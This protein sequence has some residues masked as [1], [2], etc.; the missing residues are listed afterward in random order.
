MPAFLTSLRHPPSRSVALR[1]TLASVIA[2][3]VAAMIG[4]ALP[5]WAAMAVW[6]IGQPPRGLLFERSLAQL[7]GTVAGASAGAVLVI[8][9]AGSA[10]ATLLG[11]AVWIGACCGLANRMRHQRAYGAVVCGLTSVV[12]VALTLHTPALTPADPIAF[13]VA[14]VLDNM[15]G[16][17]AALSVALAFGPPASRSTVAA[18]ANSVM[19]RTL[20]L[21]AEALTEPVENTVVKEREFLLALASLEATA[22]DAAAGSMVGRRE[23]RDIKGLFACLLDLIVVARAIRSQETF[24][25]LKDHADL[26]DLKGAIGVAASGLATSQKLEVAAVLQATQRLQAADRTLAPVLG[27]MRDLLER[28]ARG[29][30][31]LWRE[32]TGPDEWTYHPHPDTTGLKRAMARGTLVILIAS[33]VWLTF[34][35][36]PLRYFLLGAGIFTV[37]FSA[38]D[39][40]APVVRQVFLGG[41]A[42]APAATLWRLA[43]VSEVPNGWL[44]LALAIPLIFAAS[45]L[46]AQ[47]STMF[48][49]LAFNM[50]FAVLARPV[51]T[52]PSTALTMITNETLLLAGIAMTY[53]CFR[54]VLPMTTDRRRDHLKSDVQR[55]VRAIAMRAGT[56]LAPYHLAR[57]RYLVLGLAVRSGGQVPEMEHALSA[58]TLGHAVLR[59]GEA[60]A[61]PGLSD[62]SR[63]A[64]SETFRLLRSPPRDSGQQ[65]RHQAD[66]LRAGENQP[67]PLIWLL[68]VIAREFEGQ[69]AKNGAQPP[70]RERKD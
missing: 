16:V 30:G 35:A 65:L 34:D 61:Q 5:W 67:L 11:L 23:L 43:V 3:S 55:E 46:Q 26:L 29:Y 18:R 37:L 44:S 33:L 69:P 19:A 47:R 58:L 63:D 56:A 53:A 24:S 50:L 8:L 1:L 38:V 66:R 48:I 54:W 41:L 62:S 68:D 59:L 39:E 17:A 64:I 70:A 31:R 45:L 32:R 2:M 6:M 42:A 14:R 13:A 57:L 4:V 25:L 60:A 49:G 40:P 22:E 27:E 28:V 7:I 9:G 52:S 21:I 10:P 12:I 15:I 36:S 20:E 51:D